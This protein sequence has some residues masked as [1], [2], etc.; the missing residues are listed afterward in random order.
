M[1]ERCS[2]PWGLKP[3]CGRSAA[4][5]RGW[6]VLGDEPSENGPAQMLCDPHRLHVRMDDALW[7]SW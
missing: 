1:T 6:F 3:L 7:A 5:L 2:A 4:L